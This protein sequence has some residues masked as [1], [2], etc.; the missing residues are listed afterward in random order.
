MPAGPS[1]LEGLGGYSL[2]QEFITSHCPQHNGM[3][4]RVIRTLKEQ[5]VQRHRFE[6]IQN[7]ARA[8]GDLI[9]FSKELIPYPRLRSSI[10]NLAED[11]GV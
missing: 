4:E 7:A 1:G 9:Q 8:I 5:C 11:D 10:G 3:V 2:R 6:S